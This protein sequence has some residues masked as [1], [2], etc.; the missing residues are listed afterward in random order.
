MSITIASD[1]LSSIKADDIKL[2]D[3]VLS[4]KYYTVDKD[5]AESLKELSLSAKLT[6]HIIQQILYVTYIKVDQHKQ[7]LNLL[8]LNKILHKVY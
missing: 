8:K 1:I 2:F 5:K 6:E 7:N 4:R 3:N